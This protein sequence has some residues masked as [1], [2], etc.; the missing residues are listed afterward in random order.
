MDEVEEEKFEFL[1]KKFLEKKPEASTAIKL[2]FFLEFYKSDPDFRELTT[3]IVESCP[4]IKT[5]EQLEEAFHGH[6]IYRE[7]FLKM[8][9]FTYGDNDDFN[10]SARKILEGMEKA[11][12]ASKG[13]DGKE[14]LS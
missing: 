7:Y 11:I 13:P 10:L 2:V 9:G 4:G 6:A 8:K 5:V 1:M 12:K 3:R 14:T